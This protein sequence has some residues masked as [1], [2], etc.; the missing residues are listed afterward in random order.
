MA[1]FFYKLMNDENSQ[2]ER[3]IRIAAKYGHG[4]C[5][6]I[7]TNIWIDPKRWGRRNTITIPSIP[8]PEQSALIEKKETLRLLTNFIEEAIVKETDKSLIDKN[9]AATK[10]RQFYNPDPEK[11]DVINEPLFSVMESYLKAVT[12]CESRKKHFQTLIKML[13]RYE[14]YCRLRG[15]GNKYYSLDINTLTSKTLEDI[16]VFILTEHEICKKFPSIYRNEPNRT[17]LS[18]LSVRGTLVC[19]APE[20]IR[21]EDLPK[22]AIPK[23]RGLNY[24]VDLLLRFRTFY[25]WAQAQGFTNNNPFRNY[26]IGECVYGEP[27]YITI[28]DRNKIYEADFSDSP[29]LAVQRDIFILQCFLGCRVGDYYRFTYENIIHDGLEYIAN[30]NRNRTGQLVRVPL[31]P[32]AKEIINRYYDPS[33]KTIM[34]F[35]NQQ[36]YNDAIKEVF[37]R[38]GVNYMVTVLDPT[39]RQDVQV[40]ISEAASS[41]MARRTFVGNLCKKT[42]STIIVGSMSGHDPHGRSIKRYWSVDEELKR[43]CIEMLG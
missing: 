36:D 2:N 35:I 38:A 18:K 41:H 23:Q 3:Q 15:R 5:V 20:K 31:H 39:T 16:R 32:T 4:A 34:P 26:K 21:Y 37:E 40:P 11:R 24:S 28:E 6:Y 42:K 17:R 19:E 43:E 27:I 14:M 9:W 7:R 33:R 8:G 12:L 30:K 22:G 25:I 13:R 1:T 29:N 10:V